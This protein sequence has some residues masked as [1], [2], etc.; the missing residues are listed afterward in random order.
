MKKIVTSTARKVSVFGVI[1]V[2]SISPYS[3]WMQE[4]TVQNNFEYGYF[5]R[6]AP[7]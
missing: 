5:L 7:Y 4:N 6:S 1:P 3:V 2:H